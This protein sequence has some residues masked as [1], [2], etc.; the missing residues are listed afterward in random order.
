M[1]LNRLSFW[2]MLLANIH[3]AKPGLNQP[4]CRDMVH[5]RLLLLPFPHRW[6]GCNHITTSVHL[7][8]P[9]T[10]PLILP[11]RWWCINQYTSIHLSVG[12]LFFPWFQISV[13]LWMILSTLGSFGGVVE[14]SHFLLFFLVF[15][16]WNIIYRTFQQPHLFHSSSSSSYPPP[17]PPAMGGPMHSMHHQPPPPMHIMGGPSGGCYSM[18]PPMA[19]HSHLPDYNNY[20]APPPQSIF[21][22]MLGRSGCE[23]NGNWWKSKYYFSPGDWKLT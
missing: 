18:P 9:S 14:K 15:C 21:S 23:W 19:S 10:R 12:P 5:L 3:E 20:N 13:D 22:G 2:W 17:P 4:I 1:V 7:R 8:L 11:I 6:E 16:W